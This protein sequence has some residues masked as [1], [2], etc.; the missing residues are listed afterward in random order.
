L[1]EL[2][3]FNLSLFSDLHQSFLL[4]LPSFVFP[5]KSQLIPSKQFL[6]QSLGY[7]VDFISSPQTL[8]YNSF[9]IA[10]FLIYPF[11]QVAAY[12]SL[13]LVFNKLIKRIKYFPIVV[14]LVFW[15]WL[16][17]LVIIGFAEVTTTAIIRPLVTISA[18]IAMS[19]AISFFSLRSRKHDVVPWS[20][21]PT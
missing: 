18:L 3:N 20:H 12:L 5:F 6:A 19:V 7:D 17:N 16:V 11:M 1:L 13:F 15:G 9:G 21:D 4:S 2:E 8:A 10:G 14:A